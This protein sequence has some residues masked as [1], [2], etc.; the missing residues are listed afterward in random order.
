MR[1]YNF[2]TLYRTAPPAPAFAL[3][4]AAEYDD[5]WF[6]A[7]ERPGVFRAYLGEA[8]ATEISDDPNREAR[9]DFPTPVVGNYDEVSGDFWFQETWRNPDWLGLDALTAVYFSGRMILDTHEA[10]TPIFTGAAGTMHWLAFR[11]SGRS[12]E[13]EASDWWTSPA[14]LIKNQ[15]DSHLL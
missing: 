7:I 10:P 15:W 5:F 2:Y 1:L 6:D 14:V 4:W 8:V 3:A 12:G 9:I 13:W 11:L